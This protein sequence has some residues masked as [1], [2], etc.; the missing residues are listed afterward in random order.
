[1]VRDLSRK[2]K[3]SLA[4]IIWGWLL[5]VL[6]LLI[7]V[8]AGVHLLSQRTPVTDNSMYPVLREGD[9]VWINKLQYTL[10]SPSRFDVIAFRAR[11]GDNEQSIKRIIGLPGETVQIKEGKIYINGYELQE[12]YDS[13][14]IE[15]AG[16]ASTILT[17]NRDEYFVL[18]DNR[19]DSSDSR[20][21][22]VGLI[23]RDEIIGK[24]ALIC[25]PLK[26]AGI[27]R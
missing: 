25:L 2:R 9:E 4:R 17:L 22:T 20:E 14:L 6:I 18:G 23:R 15:Q 21:P 24:V 10:W 12:N 26:H 13:D 27:V 1:M 7:V 5:F 16:I 19:A 11:Y 8:F 3:R